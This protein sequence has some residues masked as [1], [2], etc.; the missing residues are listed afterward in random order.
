MLSL[1]RLIS[2]LADFDCQLKIKTF[3]FKLLPPFLQSIVA[4]HINNNQRYYIPKSEHDHLTCQHTTAPN[5]S[6]KRNKRWEQFFFKQP[7]LPTSWSAFLSLSA[8][9]TIPPELVFLK[10]PF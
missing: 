8:H 9:P 2:K 10:M 5:T 1:C 6:V 4:K 3:P 7:K